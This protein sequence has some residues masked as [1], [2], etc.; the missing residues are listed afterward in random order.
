MAVKE[1]EF[2]EAIK[3][4]AGI[5]LDAL[6]DR[7][8]VAPGED[9]S[10][11]VKVFF[12]NAESI[13][14]KEI[15]LNAPN[16]WKI[17]K[18]DAPQDANQN[19][20]R[21]EN[22]NESALFNLKVS[23]KAKPTEPYWLHHP[24]DVYLYRWAADANQTLP[25]Q[26]PVVSAE[27]KIEV[28]GTEITL[29]QPVEYRFADDVRGEIRRNLN[30]V[31]AL[32]VSLD[33]KLLVVPQSSDKPHTRRLVMS[34]TNNS[35]KPFEA[36]ASLSL[37]LVGNW[38]SAPFSQNLN[39][40]NKGEKASIA[41][42]FTIPAGTKPGIYQ[43]LPAVSFPDGVASD[44]IH[45]IA[46][47]HIRT[48]RFYTQ[49]QAQVNV[50]DLKVAPVKVGYI[51]G[52]GDAVPE[53]IR[54]MNL[55]VE[56]LGENDL[57]GG[58]LSRFDVIVVG[59]RAFQVRQ[60][61]I[62]NNQR[63][64]DYVR[65]GG[66]LIVQYQRPEYESLLPFPAKIGA[67]VV[68]ENARVTILEANHPAFN[69]PNEITDKDFENW[70]QERNL[71]SFSTFDA[72]Y[73]PLLEAHDAGEAE[74]KGGLV[75]AEIG[76]GKYVYTSYAFFRQLPAGVAGAYRIFANLLSLPKNGKPQK[77]IK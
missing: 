24:R 40:K 48:H 41:F 10:A 45:T 16:S 22:A 26:S 37:G 70:V 12:P 74:N 49:I 35:A 14:V 36:S 60:D 54:Q 23:A 61:L 56:M 6:A 8:T 75:V 11:T 2:T 5:R 58:D 7:E 1:R 20:F 72:N 15:T 30:V 69:F 34:V 31:P 43:I 27:V 4:A 76:K 71:Y 33:Q 65:A 63:I 18:T 77:N 21:R 64:L 25:F 57:N 68:D 28:G 13:K 38:Q 52:S 17:S 55:S 44:E 66:N 9:F 67:R 32:S 73:K 42:D 51:M 46:Y 50:L 3:L 53:A 62:S 39:L 19:A 47:P 59:I 29:V